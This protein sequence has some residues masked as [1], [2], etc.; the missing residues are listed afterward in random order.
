LNQLKNYPEIIKLLNRKI[1]TKKRFEE[2]LIKKDFLQNE[3]ESIV[4]QAQQLGLINDDK[5]TKIFLSKKNTHIKSNREIKQFLLKE[6]ISREI[7]DKN[8]DERNDHEACMRAMEYKKKRIPEK[9]QEKKKILYN[10]LSSRGFSSESI[11][12][13]LKIEQ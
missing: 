7:I 3:I 2:K 8:I 13:L 11:Y 4:I 9:K 10:Y 1:W 5:W 12:G 6:G